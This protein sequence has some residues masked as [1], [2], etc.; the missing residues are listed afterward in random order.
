MAARG[1]SPR[2]T[3]CGGS[4]QIA[5][6]GRAT[7]RSMHIIHQMQSN[8]HHFITSVVHPTTE[9]RQMEQ[10]TTLG[11]IVGNRGFFPNHLCETGRED[12]L[13]VLE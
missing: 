3:V 4:I 10:K 5:L 7:H 8:D 1:I 6:Y 11:V 2:D 12:I 9:V 13:R